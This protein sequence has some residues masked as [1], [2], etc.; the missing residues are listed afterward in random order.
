MTGNGEQIIESRTARYPKSVVQAQLKELIGKEVWFRTSRDDVNSGI[1]KCVKGMGHATI[2]TESGASVT[3]HA[4]NIYMTKL[5]L[6]G[7][8]YKFFTAKVDAYC[9]EINSVEDLVR[10]C[11]DHHVSKCKDHTDWE[12]RSAARKRA[13]E[14][15]GIE[16]DPEAVEFEKDLQDDLKD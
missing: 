13:M 5:D 6:L 8:N 16:I 15:M 7:A 10:F 12:A 4:D 2:Q 14:L 1:M 11:Y 3:V 9:R